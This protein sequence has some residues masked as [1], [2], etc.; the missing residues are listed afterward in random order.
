MPQA[1]MASTSRPR[2]SPVPPVPPSPSLTVNSTESDS[3]RAFAKPPSSPSVHSSIS[4]ARLPQQS[5][6]PDTYSESYSNGNGSLQNGQPS[7]PFASRPPHHAPVPSE[8]LPD[9]LLCRSTFAALEHSAGTLKRLAKTVL[10]ASA[11]YV[12]LLEQLETAEDELLSSL[13]ELGRWLEGGYGVQG[14]VFD[15]ANG[16]RK[17]ARERRAREREDLQEMVLHSLSAVKGE[18][19]RQGLTGAGSQQHRFE[20]RDA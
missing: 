14:D 12:A 2:A 16:I 17:V 5:L 4:S 8:P 3:S 7:P 18:I 6:P 13:G 10:T 20:V 1:A 11:A 19:K 9:S 15:N